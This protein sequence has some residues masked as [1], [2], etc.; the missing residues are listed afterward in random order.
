MFSKP[1]PVWIQAGGF[2]LA[3]IGGCINA[4]GL[5]SIFNHPV[6]HLS[7]TVTLLGVDVARGAAGA[8]MQS[9]LLIGIFALGCVL[10]ALII[11]QSVLK[12]G[13]RYGVTLMLEGVV[14]AVAAHLLQRGQLGGLYAAAFASGLQNAM[15]TS[16]SG[17]VIRTTHMTGIVTDVAMAVGLAVRRTP[18]DWRRIRLYLILLA[19]FWCGAALGAVAY[20]WL[21][22]NTL[23]IPAAGAGLV[24]AGYTLWKHFSGG[25]AR[26]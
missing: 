15:A 18:P 2:L 7:G 16:Y 14:L 24:G 4:V 1:V 8:A 3:G 6:S 10:T 11:G 17:A 25:A 21:G 19:G 12:A 9:A 13:R 20:V 5:L 26:R 23:L 22:A